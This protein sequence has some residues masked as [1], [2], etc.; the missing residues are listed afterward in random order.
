M[1]DDSLHPPPQNLF[2]LIELLRG[3]AAWWVVLFH[4]KPFSSTF[5]ALEPWY[6][7]GHCGVAIF[8]VLSGYCICSSARRSAGRSS[9]VLP[10]LWRRILRIYPVYWASIALIVVS[11]FV[12]MVLQRFWTGHFTYHPRIWM[13]WTWSEWLSIGTLYEIFDWGDTVPTPMNR[14]ANLNGV[15]WTLGIEVQFYAVTALMML[16]KRPVI[17][18]TLLMAVIGLAMATLPAIATS[19]LF[20]VYFPMFAIGAL[21]ARDRFHWHDVA[22]LFALPV[23]SLVQQSMTKGASL[24]WHHPL[25][26]GLTA[27]LLMLVRYHG[28][29]ARMAEAVNQSRFGRVLQWWGFRSYSLYL[30]HVPVWVWMQSAAREWIAAAL[31]RD[32]VALAGMSIVVWAFFQIVESRFLP[33]KIRLAAAHNSH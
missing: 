9:A 2:H 25:V 30:V 31:L 24:D 33:K 10:F 18:T 21:P 28:R 8:F 20:F 13:S 29:A 6:A 14:F 27:G 3:V 32:I 15:Y 4:C 12:W 23:A 19:G 1:L 5:P 26:A 7:Y 22:W 17:S 11:P 16:L